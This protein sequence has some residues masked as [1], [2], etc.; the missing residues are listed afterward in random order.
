MDASHDA[1]YFDR[2]VCTRRNLVIQYAARLP[3]RRSSCF[4]WPAAEILLECQPH[5][6]DDLFTPS[7]RA[8]PAS[9][10]YQRNFLKHLIE[11]LQDALAQAQDS[12]GNDPEDD[13]ELDD[14][15]MER[16]A[17]LLSSG[18]GESASGPP[19]SSTIQYFYPSPTTTGIKHD[20]DIS[21]DLL[22]GLNSITLN[23]SGSMISHGTTGLKTWE[24]SL[25]LASHILASASQDPDDPESL[26]HAIVRPGS[27][28]LELGSGV[29][30]LGVLCAQL[31]AEYA[32]A[33]HAS[34]SPSQS[35]HA[36][37]FMTDVSGQV[38]DALSLTAEQNNLA[39]SKHVHF[40]PLDWLELAAECEQVGK[41]SSSSPSLHSAERPV[42]ARLA[43]IAPTT[44]LAAD[45]V[46]DPAL[47]PALVQTIRAA[48]TSIRQQQSL[49]ELTLS[50]AS[51]PT[52]I[53]Y[54]A[55][56]IRN[57][58]T[59]DVFLEALR[60]N[61]LHF[62][63]IALPATRTPIPH[64]ARQPASS[65]AALTPGQAP[66]LPPCLPVFPSAHDLA[67]DGTVEL[68][69]ITLSN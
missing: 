55:S 21:T 61:Q 5:L 66:S 18:G 28:V 57:P 27:R 56:T 24:A 13:L 36:E 50:P 68:L 19:P 14:R 11:R 67:R 54:V 49:S 69:R 15:L 62:E 42:H 23:E 4:Q 34:S 33:D 37:V 47:C 65:S 20:A 63:R 58:A 53:A 12:G 31:Q 52:S 25:S 48:L 41:I 45:V 29:G 40:E 51:T 2:C 64:P 30:M 22:H 46:F 38:L 6:D 35:A 17:A 10:Q 59:Y 32:D 7:N 1:E 44:I 60:T 9:A 16:Y 43:S 26:W 8:A 3:P 39:S